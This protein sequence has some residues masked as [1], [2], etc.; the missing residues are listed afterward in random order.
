MIAVPICRRAGDNVS[1][2]I[3]NCGIVDVN[4]GRKHCQKASL[5]KGEREREK[6]K[7]KRKNNLEKKL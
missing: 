3:G 6:K 2:C 7:K 4:V 1:D 5:S